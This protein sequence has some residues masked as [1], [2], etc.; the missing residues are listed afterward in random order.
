MSST[1]LSFQN[2]SI[3][4]RTY[5][6]MN[7]L[8]FKAITGDVILYLPLVLLV[9]AALLVLLAQL[10]LL[11]LMLLLR[12]I[13]SAQIGEG[14]PGSCPGSPKKGRRSPQPRVAPSWSGSG[15]WCLPVQDKG[16]REKD[17]LHFI[18]GRTL[19]MWL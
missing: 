10:L 3:D 15:P 16:S 4:T 8:T 19:A 9:P 17:L 5:D 2:L 14:G 11:H 18:N 12:D 6:A 7:A 1:V 13:S